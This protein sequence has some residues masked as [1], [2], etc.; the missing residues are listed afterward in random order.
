MDND[1]VTQSAG[2]S[3]K[4]FINHVFNF[5]SETKTEVMNLAQYLAIVLLTL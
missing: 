1:V 3:G 2:V 4:G 5:N